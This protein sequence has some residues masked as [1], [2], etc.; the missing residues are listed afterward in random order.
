MKHSLRNSILAPVVFAL[1]LSATPAL[2][3][4]G[5]GSSQHINFHNVGM[6]QG[7]SADVGSKGGVKSNATFKPGYGKELG[8]IVLNGV[9]QGGTLVGQGL[10]SVGGVMAAPGRCSGGTCSGSPK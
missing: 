3:R 1:I 6:N 5:G 4:G 8:K 10:G 2:A 9:V 7:G